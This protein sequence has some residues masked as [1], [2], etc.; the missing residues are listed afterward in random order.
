[1][2]NKSIVFYV[3]NCLF[4]FSLILLP[5]GLV[6]QEE[7]NSNYIKI[8]KNGEEAMNFFFGNS[9]NNDSVMSNKPKLILL[10]LKLPKITN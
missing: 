7:I 4:S 8:L 1:M 3:I 2:N 5:K 6:S 10:D 9:N